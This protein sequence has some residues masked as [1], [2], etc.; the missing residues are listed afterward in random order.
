M[1]K[2][3]ISFPDD[4]ADSEISIVADTV[5]GAPQGLGLDLFGGTEFVTDTILFPSFQT[6]IDINIE[7]WYLFLEDGEGVIL[8]EGGQKILLEMQA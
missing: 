4:D 7:G 6:D 8:L 2:I 5:S 1:S 3:Q